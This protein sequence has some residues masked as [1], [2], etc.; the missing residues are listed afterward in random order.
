VFVPPPVTV[1]PKVVVVESDTKV[2]VP[3]FEVEAVG[4]VATVYT[5][6]FVIYALFMM[7]K[8]EFN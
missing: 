7:V 3:R 4:N 2:L 5:V 8:N 1:A 6:V